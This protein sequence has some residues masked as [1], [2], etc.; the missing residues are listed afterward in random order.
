MPSSKPLFQVFQILRCL[1]SVH[2]DADEI[3]LDVK[4]FE[5]Q[6]FEKQPFEKQPFEKRREKTGGAYR[7]LS[8]SSVILLRSSR[9]LDEFD[10]CSR[11]LLRSLSRIR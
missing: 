4:P 10:S 8:S 2:G 7:V 3:Y 6:T 9:S 5:K 1:L 11:F